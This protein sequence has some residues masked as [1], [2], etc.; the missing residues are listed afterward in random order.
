MEH[1]LAIRPDGVIGFLYDDSIR[2]LLEAGRPEIRRASRVEPTADGRWEADL[3]PLGGPRLGPF[4]LRREALDAE[5]AW[6]Q[7]RLPILP[8]TPQPLLRS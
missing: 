5:R 2:P 4:E 3:A 1:V 8:R 7:Q 6:L